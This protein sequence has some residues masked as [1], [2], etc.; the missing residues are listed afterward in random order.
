MHHDGSHDFTVIWW[1]TTIHHPH[2]QDVLIAAGVLDDRTFG[3]EAAGVVR[4]VGPNVHNLRAG[5]RVVMLELDTFK[6]VITASEKLCER[7]P[8]RMSFVDAA[9]MPLVFSTSIY[10]LVEVAHLRRGQ[11]SKRSRN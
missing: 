9:S 3:H 11:V 4:R 8:D 6:T 1:L 10:S 7:I 2:N 5:D